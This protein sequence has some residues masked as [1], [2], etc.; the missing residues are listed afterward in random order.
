MAAFAGV[1]VL[2]YSLK[3]VKVFMF[4]CML[5]VHCTIITNS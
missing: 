3:K 5:V 4:S 1:G 2:I